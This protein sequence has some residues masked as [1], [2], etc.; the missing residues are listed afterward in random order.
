MPNKAVLVPCLIA[1][2]LS[3]ATRVHAVPILGEQLFFT[4]GDV[5]VESLP[6]ESAFISELGLYDPTF[7]RL[8]HLMNDEPPGVVVTFDPADFGFSVGDELIFGIRVI[9]DANREYFMGPATRNLDNVLHAGVDNIA[10][11]IFVVGFEDLFTGG[12]L[13]Y[14]DNRFQ[15]EGALTRTT[16]PEP[17]TLSLLGLGLLSA[18]RY[19]RRS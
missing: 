1:V 18:C 13:D 11:G 12:D 5:M 16:V 14:D 7:T 3:L 9:S 8:I 10:P 19:R 15:F 4:G 2:L 17:G 6:V